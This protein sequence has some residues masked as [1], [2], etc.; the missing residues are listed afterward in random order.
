[1]FGEKVM[2]VILIF[3]FFFF[4]LGLFFLVL[5]SD[6]LMWFFRLE[7]LFWLLRRVVG[8]VLVMSLLLRNFCVFDSVR[9][10]LMVNFLRSIIVVVE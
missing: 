10:M 5:G 9:L 3:G 6:L 4:V 1:M 8:L 2:F 7:V